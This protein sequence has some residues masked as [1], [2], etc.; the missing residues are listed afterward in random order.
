MYTRWIQLFILALMTAAL[1]YMGCA[2]T[3]GMV[4]PADDDDFVADDDDATDDDDDTVDTSMWDGSELLVHSPMSGSF[5][6]LSDPMHLEGEVIDADGESTDFDEIVWTTDQDAE[7]EYIGAMGDVEDFPVGEHVI[8]ATAELPNGDRLIYA[9]GGVLVQHEY[10]GVY[11]G[12]VNI[13][14]DMEIQGYPISA[15]CVGS[16]DFLVDPYGEILEGSGACI[17]S[18]MGML[19]LDVSLI[20]QGEIYDELVDGTISIDIAGWFELPSTFNGEFVSSD[21]FSANFDYDYSGV[22][23]SGEVQ[24]HRVA[25]TP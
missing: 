7:F 12:T 22:A 6:P 11:S 24:A 19:D 10:A 14:I 4:L 20:I 16:T 3:S 21:E 15:S 2:D 18:V 25:L 17:A 13:N 5:V 23:V 9:V 1:G 8:K